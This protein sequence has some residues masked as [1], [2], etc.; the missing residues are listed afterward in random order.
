MAENRQ[1]EKLTC[2]NVMIIVHF[3]ISCQCIFIRTGKDFSGF[4]WRPFQ[5]QVSQDRV[6]QSF[7]IGRRLGRLFESADDPSED[8]TLDTTMQT[9][10]IACS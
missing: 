7:V 9:V 6:Y 10:R 5:H 1:Q 8:R 3:S 4:V 2:T